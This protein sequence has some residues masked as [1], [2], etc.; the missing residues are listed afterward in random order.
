[1]A[2]LIVTVASKD[3][4]AYLL[5]NK[6]LSTKSI[7]TYPDPFCILQWYRRIFHS[8][9][10]I[11]WS[12]ILDFLPEYSVKANF[13]PCIFFSV[14]SLSVKDENVL[15]CSGCGLGWWCWWWWWW[16][17]V[18]VSISANAVFSFSNHQPRNKAILSPPYN[19]VSDYRSPSSTFSQ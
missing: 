12:I 10:W 6:M 17:W 16:C 14:L 11:K 2:V 19:C 3:Y 9:P 18:L 5:V 13:L 8:S 15:N 4:I 1:M 7:I